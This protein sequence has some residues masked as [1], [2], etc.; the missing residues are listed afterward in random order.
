MS[1]AGVFCFSMSNASKTFTILSWN[2]RGLGDPEKCNLVRDAIRSANPLIVCLQETKLQECN[3]FKASSF[4]PQNLVYSYH[5]SAASVSRG[6]VLTAWDRDTFS[7]ISLHTTHPYSLTATFASTISDHSFAVTNV[8]APSDHRDSLTFLSSLSDLSQFRLGS[9][10]LAGDFNLIRSATDKNTAVTNNNLCSAFNDTINNLELLEPPLLG[11]RFTRTNKRAA[12][13]LARLD[14]MFHNVAWDQMFPSCSLQCLPRPTSDH[15]PILATLSTDIPK[16]KIFRFENAWLLNNIFLPELLPAWHESLPCDDAAGALAGHLKSLRAAAKVWSKRNRAP[17]VI[18]QNCKFIIQLFDFL[19]EDRCLSNVEIQVRQLCS[20]RLALEI[21]QKAAYW[22][23]RA[24]F[25]AVREGDS[26]TAF[27]QAQATGRMKRN[28]IRCIEVDGIQVTN[29]QSKVQALTAHFRN[30][31]G[32]AGT[33]VWQFD[34]SALYQDQLTATECLT[35]PFTEQEAKEAIKAMNRNNAPGPDGFGAG[36]YQAAWQTVSPSVM[37][38]L[39]AFYHG[40][41]QLQRVN[42]SYMVLLPKTSGAT[43]VTAFRPICLQ[44]C[45]VK[46]LAK[47][48]TTRLQSQIKNLVDLDQTGFIKGRSITENFVYAMELVQC[49]HKRRVPTLVIKLDFA[50]AFDTVNWEALDII[51]QARGFS[52][53]WRNWVMCILQS[54]HSAVLVNG[55]PGPWINCRCGL[56]QGDPMSPYL[57]ILVADVLQFLIR[58]DVGIRHPVIDAGCPVLQYADDTLLLIRGDPSDVGKLRT[59]LDQFASATGLQINYSKSTEYI[60][61][62]KQ[63]RSASQ[64]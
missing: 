9:W 19:E 17:I 8:Y 25:R 62:R 22:K 26:N 57:F 45:C 53:T 24:K 39:E 31:I 36:F 59:A 42:R 5:F 55:V 56:R 1:G 28:T 58:A 20:D 64:G 63:S 14:R 47:I 29:H 43:A 15:S 38:F 27:F 60:W 52:Q 46:I 11:N 6:G 16:T 33:S 54:S 2:V 48:L 35:A 3:F 12:P 44:N 4:L 13:T 50:K 37:A 10:L 21:K 32:T 18:I 23:Q 30:I 7:L 49:C 41:V 51:L 34:C 40:D 61:M